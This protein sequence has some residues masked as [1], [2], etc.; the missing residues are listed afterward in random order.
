MNESLQTLKVSLLNIGYAK[1]DRQWDYDNVVSPFSRLYLIKSGTAKV[2]HHRQVFDLKKDH[3]YLIPSYTYSR[4]KCDSRMEQYYVH[5][6]EET[7]VGMSVYSRYDFKYERKASPL[8]QLLFERLLA[9]NPQRALVKSD[10]KIYHDNKVIPDF[11]GINNRTPA[12]YIVETQGLLKILF[13]GFIQEHRHQ[14]AYAGN[15]GKKIIDMV[16]YI[17]EHLSDELTVQK[18]AA[19]CHLDPDYFSRIFKKETGI[20]PL[21]YLHARRI[22]RA[23]L[24]LATTAYSLQE[25]ADMVGIP[26][27]S[28][29]NRLFTRLSQRTPAAYRKASWNV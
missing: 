8:E 4:Y 1:L 5:F 25:I 29:F 22:E 14:N 11:T 24:L 28:Y 9:V 13:A 7:G 26:N 6:L 2:Y 12:K 23:Q 19:Q 15:T 20:R 18:L 27:I 16:K 3:L 17:N 21:E 10:P